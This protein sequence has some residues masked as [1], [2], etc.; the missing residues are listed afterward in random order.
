MTDR[1]NSAEWQKYS[2]EGYEWYGAV[3]RGQTSFRS[4]GATRTFLNED[5]NVH[6]RS[7]YSKSDYDYFRQS[8]KI[9]KD[10][11]G[12]IKMCRNAYDNVGIIKNT[13]D[14]MTDFANK[15]MKIVHKNK[16]IQSFLR[17]WFKYVGGKGVNDRMLQSLYRDGNII[18]ERVDAKIKPS[19]VEKWKAMGFQ[20]QQVSRNI[21]PSRYIVHNI[22][23][24]L[25]SSNE[26]VSDDIKF[27]LVLNSGSEMNYYTSGF[28]NPPKIELK[29]GQY[30]DL[31]KDKIYDY[32]YKKSDWETWARP[33]TFAIMNELI[34]LDKTQ[35]A[36]MSALDGAISNVRLWTLGN[37][38]YNVFPNR[39][40]ID[41]VRNILAKNVGGGVLDLVWGPEL[42]FSESSTQVHH[43]LGK[44]KYEAILTLIYAGLGV[45]PTLTG[46]SSASGF[47]NNFIS[48]KTLIERLQYGRDILVDFW[49]QQLDLVM[50]AMGFS[51]NA[52]VLFTYNVLSDD[53]AEKAL[54]RDIWDRDILSTESVL[55]MMGYDPDI[56]T[57]KINREAR[58]R[59]VSTPEKAGPYHNPFH[60]EEK[61]KLFI[62]SKVYSPSEFGLDLE[63]KKGKSPLEIEQ[64]VAPTPTGAAPSAKPA[65]NPNG[66]PKN[67]VDTVKRKQK[68]VKPTLG[69]IQDMMWYASAK[70]KVD[71]IINPIF[72]QSVS[73]QNLRYL[74]KEEYLTL[75]RIKFDC[76]SNLTINEEFNEEAL[77]S[78]L[79]CSCEPVALESALSLLR[80]FE[81]KKGPPTIEQTKDIYLVSLALR[82]NTDY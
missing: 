76:L 79:D 74:T 52:R 51:G 30:K 40:G 77:I 25:K 67:A 24:I 54:I 41:K 21:I 32:Y 72:L 62:Q 1:N 42:T 70:E 75:E 50:R 64:E 53:A 7:E 12:V 71:E 37:F 16:K 2:S 60:N 11:N 46:S 27:A 19:T 56:E 43:F 15:G 58:K 69:F 63:D 3:G 49:E 47:T 65:K 14:L 10:F 29:E 31:D 9:C 39:E 61:E 55:E 80:D 59:G 5:T 36:D 68:T 48:L 45:P 78:V 73:K 35:L 18:T 82:E 4:S 44:E 17:R 20:E 57:I 23:S 8:E 81:E 13:V 34:M 22:L 26:V 28:K 38:E 66:R 6:I 33:M